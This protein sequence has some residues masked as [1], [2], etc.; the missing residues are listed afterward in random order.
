MDVSKRASWRWP[1]ICYPPSLP[2]SLPF[3]CTHL[4]SACTLKCLVVPLSTSLHL[5]PP[6]PPS[7][8]S[9]LPSRPS[10]PFSP[11]FRLH[12]QMLDRAFIQLFQRTHQL[13]LLR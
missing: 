2:P 4:D 11:A 6:F 1:C 7:L 12:T 3:L 8:P 13:D 5:P 10:L 9:S